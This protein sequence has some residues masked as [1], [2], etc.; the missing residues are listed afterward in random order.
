M[1]DFWTE[2]LPPANLWTAILEL[3]A[4]ISGV[5]ALT[6]NIMA[7]AQ[8]LETDQRE[9]WMFTDRISEQVKMN[10]AQIAENIET[11]NALV[12]DVDNLS[13]SVMTL[14]DSV[15]LLNSNIRAC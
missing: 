9:L 7:M 8:S 12:V 4:V 3:V 15:G 2:K 6:W 1:T 5:V 11:L 13:V 10:A 14:Q